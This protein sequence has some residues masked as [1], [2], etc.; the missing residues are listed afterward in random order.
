M[1]LLDIIIFNHLK[2]NK[3][4]YLQHFVISFQIGT[5]LLLCSTK[6]FIHAVF[7]YFFQNSTKECITCIQYLLNI[8][9][10]N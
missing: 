4:T 6:S 10:N 3:I 2:D 8:M 9:D 1:G 7:P 5:Y